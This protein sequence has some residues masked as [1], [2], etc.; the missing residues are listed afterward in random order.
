M[1]DRAGDVWSNFEG[2][3]ASLWQIQIDH[4]ARPSLT[5]GL[6]EGFTDFLKDAGS[7]SDDM[8]KSMDD[9]ASLGIRLVI[10]D[11]QDPDGCLASC[12]CTI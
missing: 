5:F 6:R 9:L 12:P 3:D 11:K 7:K 8:P 2:T 1:T 10:S 4:A